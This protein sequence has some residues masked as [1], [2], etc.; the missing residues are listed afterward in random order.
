MLIYNYLICF[1]LFLCKQMNRVSAYYNN[2][3]V[4]N[5]IIRNISNATK[6]FYY[7]FTF[8]RTEP[9][10]PWVCNCSIQKSKSYLLV[11]RYT[12][13]EQ[14][15]IA[16]I[17]GPYIESFHKAS[18]NQIELNNLDKL[19]SN[20]SLTITKLMNDEVCYYVSRNPTY[21]TIE[22][23]SAKFISIE[24]CHPTMQESVEIILDKEWF[25][26]GNELFT[27]T[28]V[29]RALEHQSQKY[30]FD[31]NYKIKILDDSITLFEFGSESYVLLTPNGYEIC[32]LDTEPIEIKDNL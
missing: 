14:N 28:F 13:V 15:Y 32:D 25:Y 4:S 21:E 3:Y 5:A 16:S 19:N 24:Y 7:S 2:L 9:P 30:Y 26:A 6:Y 20:T 10:M 12:S 31:F 29:L 1:F 8:Q 11:E 23:S 18:S 27:P 17:I 22:K